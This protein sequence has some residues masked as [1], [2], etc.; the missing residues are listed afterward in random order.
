MKNKLIRFIYFFLCICNF[1]FADSFQ[2]E[3]SKI[4]ILKNDNQIIAINGKAISSDKNLE[5]KGKL[6]QYDK[7]IN[8]LNVINGDVAIKTNNLKINFYELT[9]DEKNLLITAK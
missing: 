9:I 3:V 2:F 6:F 4:D 1:A 5:I 8:K 7:N